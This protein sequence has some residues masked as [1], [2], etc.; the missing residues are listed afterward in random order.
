MSSSIVRGC[1]LLCEGVG[2]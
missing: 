1:G 2:L